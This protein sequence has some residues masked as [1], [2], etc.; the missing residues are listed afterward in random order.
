MRHLHK[1]TALT[2]GLDAEKDAERNI[3]EHNIY[4]HKITRFAILRYATF[5]DI[6]FVNSNNI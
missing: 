6:L 4:E 5:H 3:Y 2:G 1:R